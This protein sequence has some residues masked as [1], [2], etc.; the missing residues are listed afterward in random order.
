MEAVLGVVLTGIAAIITA[1]AALV[2]ASRWANRTTRSENRN[3]HEYREVADRVIRL[4]GIHLNRHS[5]EDNEEIAEAKAELQAMGQRIDQ[6][7]TE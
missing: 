7:D 1:I 4:Q 2:K 3:L 6:G 5:I